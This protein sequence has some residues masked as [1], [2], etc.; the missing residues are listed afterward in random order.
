MRLV[1]LETLRHALVGFPGSFGLSMEWRKTHDPWN[2]MN[3]YN[4][5][6]FTKT[7]YVSFGVDVWP[8]VRTAMEYMDQFERDGDGLVENDGFPNQTYDTWTVHGVDTIWGRAWHG[9]ELSLLNK[10]F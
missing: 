5:H 7:G 6:D 9:I 8:A 2:E 4:I 10:V 1:Q 3:A